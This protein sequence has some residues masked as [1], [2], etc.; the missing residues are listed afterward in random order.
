MD[1]RKKFA[2]F[3]MNTVIVLLIVLNKAYKPLLEKLAKEYVKRKNNATNSFRMNKE[4]TGFLEKAQEIIGDIGNVVIDAF[5]T[6]PVQE[7]QESIKISPR[8]ET[9]VCQKLERIQ[10]GN[11]V[12]LVPKPA[13]SVA[14][15]S[16]MAVTDVISNKGTIPSISPQA[17]KKLCSTLALIIVLNTLGI[18]NAIEGNKYVEDAIIEDLEEYFSDFTV[19]NLQEETKP[20]I[21]EPVLSTEQQ[22]QNILVSNST[23]VEKFNEILSVDGISLDYAISVIMHSELTNNSNL[24]TYILSINYL[25]QS[26]KMEYII[27]YEHTTYEELYHFIH[28]TTELTL[29]QKIWY[30]FLIPDVPFQRL[31]EDLLALDASQ[32]QIIMGIVQTDLVPFKTLFDKI[33]TLEGLTKDQLTNYLV[34]YNA[35]YNAVTLNEL[36]NYVLML[37][38]FTPEE[39]VDTIWNI[40]SIYPLDYRIAFILDFHQASYKD[41]IDLLLKNRKDYNATQERMVQLFEKVNIEKEAY[42]L[43]NYAF[44]SKEQ[45]DITVAGCAAEGAKSYDDL[46]CVANTI[47]NRI[48]DTYYVGK[49]ENPYLQFIAPSQFEV[50]STG[51]YLRYLY[52]VNSSYAK[53]YQLAKQAFY[54]MFYLG[55]D[56]IVHSYLEFRSWDTVTFSNNIAVVGGNRYGNKMNEKTRIQYEQLIKE[57]DDTNAHVL[58]KKLDWLPSIGK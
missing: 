45:L 12:Q 36:V 53:K 27:N 13:L 44:D 9:Y 20:S 3:T 56:G 30:L 18:A 7:M 35:I 42:I 37:D 48:T 55:Y 11:F 32:E 22:I 24:F 34:S 14:G 5:T 51:S 19:V 2:I 57:E 4:M 1:K 8:I 31:W 47:F 6:Y 58:T 10:E 26:K 28:N 15:G 49:G 39:Q 29:E 41:Y 25:Q 46:Y 50:Y 33:L 23:Y 54:D 16:S 17:F 21:L 43:E 40:L 52:P 38:V